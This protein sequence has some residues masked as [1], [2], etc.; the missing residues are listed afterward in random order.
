MG[1]GSNNVM[2]RCATQTEDE[3]YRIRRRPGFKDLAAH[4]TAGLSIRRAEL[5]NIK[6][7]ADLE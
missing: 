7:V 6:S 3:V 4:L 2:T 5:R 1:I